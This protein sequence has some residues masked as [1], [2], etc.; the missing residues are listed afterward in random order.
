MIK[1][2][3]NELEVENKDVETMI[4]ELVER[5]EYACTGD[6]CGANACGVNQFR[7]EVKDM[8]IY[9]VNKSINVENDNIDSL[10]EELSERNEFSCTGNTCPAHSCGVVFWEDIVNQG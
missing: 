4:E 1:S 9:T 3:N 6:A 2:I 10:M 5:D 8:G 7:K